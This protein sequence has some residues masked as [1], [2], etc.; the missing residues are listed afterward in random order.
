MQEIEKFLLVTTGILFIVVG[1]K[2]L[3]RRL[4]KNDIIPDEFPYLFPIESSFVSG[5]VEL[6]Y[7]IPFATLVRISLLNAEHQEE[8]EIS[9]TEKAKG[10]HTLPLNSVKYS[11]GFYYLMLVTSEQKIERRIEIKN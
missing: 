7:E 10:T 6:K 3:L 5:V 4:R 2:W 8:L 9:N 1:Y 11:N